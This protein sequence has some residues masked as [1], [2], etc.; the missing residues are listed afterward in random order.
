M[1][2]TAFAIWREQVGLSQDGAAR[3]L[4]VATRT[5]QYWD[6]GKGPRQERMVPPRSVRLVMTAIARKI[7]LEPWP[8]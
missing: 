2:K 7:D 4:D 1:E 8:E 6:K 5:V 3:A